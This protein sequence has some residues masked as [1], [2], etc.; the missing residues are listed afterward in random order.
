MSV[1]KECTCPS[2]YD[3]ENYG[4]SDFCPIHGEDEFINQHM[5]INKTMS[6]QTQGVITK[7]SVT[8][9]PAGA[10]RK[11]T[12]KSFLVNDEWYGGFVN[13]DNKASLDAV[14]EGD[15]VEISYETK[16]DYKNLVG[17]KLIAKHESENTNKS[18]KELVTS[19]GGLV[20]GSSNMKPYNPADKDFRITY[21]ASRRDAI[22]FVKA[23]YQM[24]T[25]TFGKKK[26]DEMDIF[27]DLVH[28]YA[29]KF[30]MKS[31][32]IVPV[33]QTEIV[34]STPRAVNE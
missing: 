24:G 7:V 19:S 18:Y 2:Y 22:E 28:T 29:M 21:L 26:A 27:E 10:A 30:A 16:G 20:Q 32:E 4:L 17:I 6:N 31:W 11:W 9:S 14:G 8:Q 25:I 34:A 23:A 15:A 3:K 5:R 1:G 12:K 33:V 13:A